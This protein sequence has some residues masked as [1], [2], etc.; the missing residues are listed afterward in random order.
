[1]S[2]IEAE[3]RRRVIGAGVLP[4]I[5]A[6]ETERVMTSLFEGRESARMKQ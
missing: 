1:V 2:V 5:V 6:F 3:I 4:E